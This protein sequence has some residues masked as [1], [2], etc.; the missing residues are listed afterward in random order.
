MPELILLV[1]LFFITP[2][3][4]G[5]VSNILASSQKRAWCMQVTQWKALEY[6]VALFVV[7]LGVLILATTASQLTGWKPPRHIGVM[8]LIAT[9][10]SAATYLWHFW[11]LSSKAANHKRVLTAVGGV[12]TLTIATASKISSD[13]AIAEFTNLSPQELPGAQLL[14][15][16]ILTPVLWVLM[17]SLLLGYAS[18]PLTLFILGKGIYTDWKT[19]KGVKPTTSTGLYISAVLALCY[20]TAIQ[21]IMISNMLTTDVYE[22]P[23]RTAVAHAAFLLPPSYCGLPDTE[24]AGIAVLKYRRAGLAIPHKDKGYEFS[25]VSCD[26]KPQTIEAASAKLAT[27]TAS[28]ATSL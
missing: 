3:V 17:L 7:L 23:L 2:A 24:G 21:L 10:I 22:K 5:Q 11:G 12:L 6:S 1:L 28:V 27:H 26:P 25:T 9:C 8:L 14:L 20:F 18:I 19:N 16:F 13:M 4:A 15:T